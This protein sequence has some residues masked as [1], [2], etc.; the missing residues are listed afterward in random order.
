MN[1]MENLKHIKLHRTRGFSPIS[2]HGSL[3]GTA[4]LR[5]SIKTFQGPRNQHV[6]NSMT[7]VKGRSHDQDEL[8]NELDGKPEAHYTPSDQRPQSYLR[9]CL[10]CSELQIS[11]HPS[12]LSKV[13]EI[14][15]SRIRCPM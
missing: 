11:E 9:T 1:E 7:C 12:K 4:D 14:S 13:F 6:E 15:M 3:L 5:T 10:G 8:P 2:E